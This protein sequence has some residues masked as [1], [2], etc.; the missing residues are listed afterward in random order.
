[1]PKI[2]IRSRLGIDGP[3]DLTANVQEATFAYLKESLSDQ[4]RVSAYLDQDW[5]EVRAEYSELVV[6]GLAEGSLRIEKVI[7]GSRTR[8]GIVLPGA[9]MEGEQLTLIVKRASSEIPT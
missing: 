9:M 4:I 7:P 3:E 8:T 6:E 5:P 2:Q 1:M